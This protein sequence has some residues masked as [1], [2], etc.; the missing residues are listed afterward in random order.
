MFELPTYASTVSIKIKN[1]S[2][3]RC[4]KVHL[5]QNMPVLLALFIWITQIFAYKYLELE[6]RI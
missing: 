6:I 2:H 5:T 3:V 1:N 4:I